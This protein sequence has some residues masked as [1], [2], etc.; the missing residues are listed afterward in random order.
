MADT[1]APTGTTVI[2]DN[3]V[4]KI[5]G[6][7]AREVPGV[8]GLGGGTPRAL[9]AILDAI[10]GTDLAQGVSIE[11]SDSQ[12]VIDLS[13]VA[14]Y[15]TPL[16]KVADDVR[17]A[18]VTAIETLVGLQVTA[19]NVTVTDVYVAPRDDAGTEASE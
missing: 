3:V 9:G 6:I 12:V 19:V 16:Q 5:A 8:Y 2:T 1:A 17:T 7:A 10:S 13:L 15:P 18:V 4:S 14:T 11:L